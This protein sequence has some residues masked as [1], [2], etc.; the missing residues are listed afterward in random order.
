M[1]NQARPS[2]ERRTL[3]ALERFRW[4]DER[5]FSRTFPRTVDGLRV[6][7]AGLPATMPVRIGEDVAF[8]AETI[9][10]LRAFDEFYLP[11]LVEVVIPYRIDVHH[12]IT[13][14]RA[15]RVGETRET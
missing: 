9:A 6:A 15:D 4:M 8:T 7:I 5:I 3:E 2:Q 1:R 14:N 10:D 12:F 13:V 11:H